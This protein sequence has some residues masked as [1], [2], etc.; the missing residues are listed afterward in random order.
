V[1][2]QQKGCF[3]AAALF[4]AESVLISS[5]SSNIATLLTKNNAPKLRKQLS[6]TIPKMAQKSVETFYKIAQFISLRL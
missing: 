1:I 5:Y 4:K 3:Q 6:R 2:L